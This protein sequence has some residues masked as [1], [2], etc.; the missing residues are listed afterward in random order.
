MCRTDSRGQPDRWTVEERAI[1]IDVRP[2]ER[3]ID[4]WPIHNHHHPPFVFFVSLLASTRLEYLPES[5]SFTGSMAA[6]SYDMHTHTYTYT[7]VT[8][9]LRQSRFRSPRQSSIHT[10]VLPRTRTQARKQKKEK[11]TQDWRSSITTRPR[12]VPTEGQ[13]QVT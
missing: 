1:S 12:S 11:D 10:N 13:K 7:H 3:T 5:G 4:N 2:A 8:E 6:A 9:T